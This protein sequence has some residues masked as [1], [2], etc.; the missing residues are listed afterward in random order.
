MQYNQLPTK[1]PV[2]LRD[3]SN[4]HQLVNSDLLCVSSYLS[5]A[6]IN[7][8]KN[9]MITFLLDPPTQRYLSSW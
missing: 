5:T 1:S 3:D 2:E 8:Q 9:L 7:A 4:S 6:H